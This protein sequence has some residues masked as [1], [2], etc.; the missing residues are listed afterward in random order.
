MAF[1]ATFREGVLAFSTG[2][3]AGLA[4]TF[5]IRR[6][7]W[8]KAQEQ[9]QAA[10]DC[11]ADLH[12]VHHG[13]SDEP[14]RRQPVAIPSLLDLRLRRDIANYWNGCVTSVYDRLGRGL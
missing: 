7:V 14:P 5:Y 12:A 3:A 6:T 2:A 11:I 9:G 10:D 13:T 4:A 1:V 8:L